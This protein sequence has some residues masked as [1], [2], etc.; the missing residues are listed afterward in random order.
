M[1]RKKDI[2][3]VIVNPKLTGAIGTFGSKAAARD[4]KKRHPFYETGVILV[5]VDTEMIEKKPK[6][7][8]NK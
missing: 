2:E 5:L 1:G 6:R 7:R 3:W 8:A 4:F